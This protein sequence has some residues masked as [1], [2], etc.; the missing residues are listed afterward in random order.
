MKCFICSGES[1]QHEFVVERED[2]YRILVSENA[3]KAV[4]KIC[5]TCEAMNFFG[6]PL[7]EQAYSEGNYYSVDGDAKEFIRKR[8]EKVLALPPESSDNHCR[9]SRI[10]HFLHKR[11][12][13][14]NKNPRR[15]LDVGAGMGVFLARFLEDAAWDATAVEPDA[16]ATEHIGEVLPEVRTVLGTSHALDPEERFELITLNRVLE[17]LDS[18]LSELE[19]LRNFLSDDGVMYLELPDVL[20]YY[21]D[22]PDNEAF[23]YGHFVVYSPLAMCILAQKAGLRVLELSRT[24]EPSTKFTIYGFFSKS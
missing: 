8:Y 23:G 9:V 7:T 13:R 5:Q 12:K 11:A 16:M 21:D 24:V 4:Y 1:F 18:P 19:T 17:H 14:E 3:P 22:G 2:K 6:P 10:N 20:S 15:V